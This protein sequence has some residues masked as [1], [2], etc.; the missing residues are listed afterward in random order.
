MLTGTSEVICATPFGLLLALAAGTGVTA[1]PKGAVKTIT[2]WRSTEAALA[3]APVGAFQ[4]LSVAIL[5][6]APLDRKFGSRG[7]GDVLGA[8][9]LIVGAT[10][11]MAILGAACGL[12][13]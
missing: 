8:A 4:G 3:G 9:V 2:A 12:L 6:P 13:G 11:A 10:A 7:W 1:V 5:L